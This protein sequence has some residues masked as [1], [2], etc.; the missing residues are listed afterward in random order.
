MAMRPNSVYFLIIKH[1]SRTC[2]GAGDTPL[3]PVCAPCFTDRRQD[4]CHC[5]QQDADAL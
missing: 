5:C 3:P 2:Y 4:R 1:L